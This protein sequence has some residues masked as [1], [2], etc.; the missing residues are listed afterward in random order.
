MGIEKLRQEQN[1]VT[2]WLHYPLHRNTPKEGILMKDLYKNRD[3]ESVRAAGD[4]LKNA[5]SEA[6]LV[7]NRRTRLDNSRIA[8]E[9]GAWADT[10][11]NSEAFHDAMFKA[12]FADDRTISDNDTLVE[13]AESVGMDGA[14]ARSV[15][16]ERSFSDAVTRDWDR[17]WEDGIT[18]VPTFTARDLFVFGAQPYEVLLRFYNHLVKLRAGDTAAD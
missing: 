5:M 16:E 12:Y 4:H 18:G 11:E 2:K 1:V 10:Q 13:I 3:P 7:Y 9:L 6:G 14:Q 15:I 8:Q 17:A